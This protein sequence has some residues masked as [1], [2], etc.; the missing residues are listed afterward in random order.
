[1]EYWKVVMPIISP[2]LARDPIQDFT[3]TRPVIVPRDNVSPTTRKVTD[4]TTKTAPP[5][6]YQVCQNCMELGSTLRLLDRLHM[7]RRILPCCRHESQQPIHAPAES[8]SSQAYLSKVLNTGYM[9]PGSWYQLLFHSHLRS[10]LNLW[11]VRA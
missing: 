4:A 9:V 7:L 5:G 3:R 10:F 2:W 8:G 1:M 11:T 6:I